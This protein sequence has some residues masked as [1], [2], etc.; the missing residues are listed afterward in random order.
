VIFFLHK[1]AFE[2]AISSSFSTKSS[3]ITQASSYSPYIFS[4]KAAKNSYSSQ[5]NLQI[6]K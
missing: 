6:K 4:F 3:K 5:Y 2:P 1:I